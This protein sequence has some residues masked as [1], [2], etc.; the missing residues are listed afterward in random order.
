M[1]EGG[2][3]ERWGVVVRG[4]IRDG[5]IL[6][7]GVPGE[8]GIGL[9]DWQLRLGEGSGAATAW[10]LLPS[11]CAILREMASFASA[12]VATKAD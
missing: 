2:G 7:V 11:A 1:W 6:G 3:S 8:L 12:G 10:P 5:G 9:L 4:G